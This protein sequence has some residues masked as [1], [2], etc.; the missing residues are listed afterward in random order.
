MLPKINQMLY[1]HVASSEADEVEKEYK[2]RIADTANETILIENPIHEPSGKMKKLFLGDEL[3][4]YFVSEEGIKHYFD[5]H[6]LGFVQDNVRL[7][8]IRMPDPDRITKVQRRNF[9][10]VPAE[11]E[12]AVKT[13]GG[14]RF[15]AVTDDAS[16]GGISFFCD[17]RW[18][19]HPE[20]VLEC[21]LLLAYKNGTVEH[22]PFSA[23][24]VR[25]VEMGSGR[26]QVMT[27][28]VKINDSERQKI[29]RFCFE[30]QFD[31]RN[32]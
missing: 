4:V 10:R 9:L 26:K 2:A 19:L 32:R 12:L 22:A 20:Q 28:F 16:G 5:S 27:K 15:I 13:P 31:F 21:W 25:I 7:V 24:I 23:E 11:L 1:I 6:V 18:E 8:K 3:S 30:R 29:I 14:E 17:S